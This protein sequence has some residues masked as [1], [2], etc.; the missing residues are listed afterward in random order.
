MISFNK[1]GCLILLFASLSLAAQ[2]E[3]PNVLFI[4]VDDL[5]NWVGFL[6]NHP[7]VK[8]PHMDQLAKQGMV[9]TNAYCSAPGCN[10]SRSSLFTGLRPSST[11]I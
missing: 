3:R 10:A 2:S 6:D 11:G 4:A 5:N 1:A 9:F 7:G 8:T